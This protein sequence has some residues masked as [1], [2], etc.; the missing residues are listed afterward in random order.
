MFLNAFLQRTGAH[1][2]KQPTRLPSRWRSVAAQNLIAAR[3]LA[4]PPRDAAYWG[5][6]PQGTAPGALLL[7]PR[8]GACVLAG[9][10]G[11]PTGRAIAR[12]R[13]VQ[14]ILHARA[15][16]TTACYPTEATRARVVRI[17]LPLFPRRL[18]ST[19]QG[20]SRWRRS[21]AARRPRTF[22]TAGCCSRTSRNRSHGRCC[23]M[24][25]YVL[26]LRSFLPLVRPTLPADVESHMS[27]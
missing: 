14:L 6:R 2:N 13:K 25:A 24:L 26:L 23:G 8:L 22:S 21:K 10:A 7:K 5:P 18:C 4:P 9:T 20:R 3:L 16:L 12:V 15:I 1:A 11:R 17:A 27:Q 19:C